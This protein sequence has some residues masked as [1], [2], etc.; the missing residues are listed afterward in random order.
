MN[1]HQLLGFY[2]IFFCA[3]L[4]AQKPGVTITTAERDDYSRHP[5]L[6]EE[7]LQ[8]G[9]TFLF[10]PGL[11]ILTDI[12]YV[13]VF[14]SDRAMGRT[15]FEEDG[16]DIGYYRIKLVKTGREDLVVWA[17]IKEDCR[18]TIDVRYLPETVAEDDKT[19]SREIIH[20]G[21]VYKDIN[22]DDPFYFNRIQFNKTLFPEG[23]ADLILTDAENYPLITLSPQTP[24]SP[25]DRDYLY[26]WEGNDID[27]NPVP[28]GEYSLYAV[29]NF[30]LN[31]SFQLD[32]RF[33][34]KAGSYFS[35]YSG[36]SLVPTAQ[37]L[38]P[39]SLQV[40]SR[41]GGNLSLSDSSESY[42]LPFSFFIRYSPLKRWETAF[43]AEVSVD[44][45]ESTPEV[46]VNTSQKILLG[47]NG[48]VLFSLNGR[49]S[50]RGAINDFSDTSTNRIVS[51][52]AG[53]SLAFP[54]QLKVHLWDFY[55]APELQYSFEPVLASSNSGGDLTGAVRWGVSYSDR[56]FNAGFSSALY[57]G[58]MKGLP[59]FVQNAADVMLYLPRSPL[60][61]HFNVI[62][63]EIHEG[64]EEI[65]LGL[66]FGFLL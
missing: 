8:Q 52:P 13:E 51:D 59:V 61:F 32:R 5:R 3:F 29:S 54:V 23:E 44:E 16:I 21:S 64:S 28:D 55:F 6:E 53:G 46:S 66:G 26:Y 15:P 12:E 17:N 40:G 41:M 11:E 25:D 19:D 1:K 45:D 10:S 9:R 42:K 14:L 43:S 22:P 31:T 30:E 58:S 33:S 39:G 4:Y 24:S 56:F 57:S 38:F 20:S 36:L 35:G 60:Y 62:Y 48:P 65:S 2:L 47:S 27:G 18:T 34:R 50:L 7:D 63:Q 49:F 37:P